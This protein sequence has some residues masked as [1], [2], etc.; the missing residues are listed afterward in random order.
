MT[1][2]EKQAE[3]EETLVNAFDDLADEWRDPVDS[4]EPMAEVNKF[5]EQFKKIPDSRKDKA[6][7]CRVRS[8]GMRTA[9]RQE[10][11]GRYSTKPH[12]TAQRLSCGSRQL[13]TPL[14]S[15]CWRDR[16]GWQIRNTHLPDVHR[17]GNGAS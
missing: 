12:T 6:H 9:D 16:Y 5:H 7:P 8:A 4:N 13:A 10:R 15:L 2:E 11:D 14:T 3:R 17:F 1:E